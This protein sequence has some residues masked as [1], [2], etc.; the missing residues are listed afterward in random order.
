[1]RPILMLVLATGCATVNRPLRSG[2]GLD[3]ATTHEVVDGVPL[4]TSQSV[5]RY[6]FEGN[7]PDEMRADIDRAKP[8]LGAG[9]WDALTRWQIYWTFRFAPDPECHVT[10]ATVE[11]HLTFVLPQW[12][13]DDGASE[14]TRK[15]WSEY[16]DHLLIHELGHAA[17]GREA[18]AEIARAL[19][20]HATRPSCKELEAAAQATAEK[21]IRTYGD[22]DVRYD[23][24]TQHG[25]AQGAFFP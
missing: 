24:D 21:V 22:L 9:R 11:L 10:E 15:R 3:V 7:T 20:H 5:V 2:G 14:A 13:R 12:A 19:I 17:H 16:L 6:D 23:S 8:D 4:A 18:A 1:M 25:F